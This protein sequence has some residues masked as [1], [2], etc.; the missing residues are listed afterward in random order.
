M[1]RNRKVKNSIIDF[2]NDTSVLDHFAVYRQA[3]NQLYKIDNPYVGSKRGILPEIADTLDKNGVEFDTMLD[4]FSGSGVVSIF[5]KLLG[6][7]VISNDLLTSSYNNCLVFCEN[8]NQDL[9]AG[10]SELD[11]LC[12]KSASN[13]S[14][15]QDNY[16]D[17]FS[18][19][20]AEVLDNYRDNIDLC[21]KTLT[22]RDK[23]IKK[24]SCF[25]SITHYI[26]NRCFLGGRLNKGQVIAEFNHRV[27]HDRN[28]GDLMA[29]N[30]A[31]LP[32]F[33][34]N[35]S[36]I[37]KSF[38]LDALVAV[39]EVLKN[40]SPQLVYLDPPYG[41]SQSNYADMY[42]FCEEYIYQDK[43]DN[44]PH[45][46]EAAHKFSKKKNY[47]EHFSEVLN[48][49]KDIPTWAISF[50]ASSFEDAEGVVKLLKDFKKQVIVTNIDHEYRYR[51]DRGSAVEY[52]F[53]AR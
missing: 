11:M 38:N 27:A 2:D 12:K 6:K 16:P 33:K 35:G 18:P 31:P 15:I 21:I 52:L 49:I 23:E 24:A 25:L 8:E 20:E 47:K 19:E 53:I 28:R 51:K 7:N 30:I 3:Q 13:S 50:N 40:H 48:E 46:K 9:N 34:G 44:L 17:K 22:G 1:S 5:F 26:L 10:K 14:F 43:I 39:K 29:F 32:L 42:A 4:L 41:Q 45:I 36:Q 37:C